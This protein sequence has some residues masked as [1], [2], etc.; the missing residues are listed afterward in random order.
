MCAIFGLI[1][2]GRVFSTDQREN[3]INTLAGECE[4]RGIDATGFAYNKNKHLTIY[5]RPLRASSM[6]VKLPPEANVILG[7]TR[8]TT[9]GKASLNQNNHPFRGSI[10]GEDFALAHNG[11]LRNDVELSRSE[12]LPSTKIQTDSYVAVQLLEKCKNL[13]LESLV[14]V[15][16]KIEGS[17]VFTL[18]DRQNN[19]YFVHGNNPLVIYH[20]LAGGFYIYASTGAILQSALTS[21]D[22]EKLEYKK[23]ETV[24]GDILKIDVK[25]NIEQATFYLND[26][27]CYDF[28]NYY[29][30]DDSE[31]IYINQLKSFAESVGVSEE[32]ID[33]LL[34]YGYLVDDVADLLY[35]PGAIEE[36]ISAL[37]SEYFYNT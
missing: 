5:K 22:L 15:A 23:I 28:Y 8:M 3:I 13:S 21:L 20:C 37:Y 25:G 12:N 6:Q 17:F 30:Y 34:G 14:T 27:S 1:D 32:D 16:E 11:I 35:T 2:Y 19:S 18:L 31:L 24:C 7:H 4:V 26:F 9:Q 29:L 33:L 36:T 10:D